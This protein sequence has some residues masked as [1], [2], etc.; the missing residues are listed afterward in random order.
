MRLTDTKADV[1]VIAF[2]DFVFGCLNEVVCRAG[3][4][5]REEAELA[6]NSNAVDCVDVVAHAPRGVDLL[7]ARAHA[8]VVVAASRSRCAQI[9]RGVWQSWRLGWANKGNKKIA[10][11]VTKSLTAAAGGEWAALEVLVALV[12]L[13]VLAARPALVGVD[14]VAQTILIVALGI[15]SV[16]NATEQKWNHSH[17][18]QAPHRGSD[19]FQ[20]ELK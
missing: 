2:R 3:P 6:G 15:I 16:D 14:V 12:V 7:V 13:S 18:K 1:E 9:A 4:A 5:R 17:P 11:E 10:S 8:L 19:C 20:V